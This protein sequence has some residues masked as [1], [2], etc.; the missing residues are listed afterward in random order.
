MSCS[1]WSPNYR[2]SQSE[3]DEEFMEERCKK[4]SLPDNP[5]NTDKGHYTYIVMCS[6][7]T[8]YTGYTVDL[9]RRLREHNSGSG[10]RYTR[11]RTP[12]KLVYSESFSTQSEAQKREHEIKQMSRQEKASLAVSEGNLPEGE[13]RAQE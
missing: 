3:P 8:L 5:D 13:V 9:S 12:V 6:D 7:N 1:N 10:A 4:E 2:M 11:G